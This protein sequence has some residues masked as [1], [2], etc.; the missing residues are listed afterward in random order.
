MTLIKKCDVKKYRTTRPHKALHPYRPGHVL[1]AGDVPANQAGGAMGTVP[2]FVADFV[3]EHS[4]SSEFAILTTVPVT[5]KSESN[6]VILPPATAN[7]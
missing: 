3:L 4:S 6:P 5:A 1:E 7:L 2:V